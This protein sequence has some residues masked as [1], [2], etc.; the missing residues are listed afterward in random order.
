MRR[1]SS[2]SRCCS[3]SR[4]SSR[5]S[6]MIAASSTSCSR[7]P[8]AVGIASTWR[9]PYDWRAHGMCAAHVYASVRACVRG[10]V[11]A[12]VRACVRVCECVRTCCSSVA[13]ALASALSGQAWATPACCLVTWQVCSWRCRSSPSC[14]RRCPSVLSSG[15]SESTDFQY[16][17]HLARAAAAV[18]L[19][20]SLSL[21]RARRAVPAVAAECA[22]LAADRD[23]SR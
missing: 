23:W 9:R 17:V 12:W 7:G 14:T 21:H 1:T 18:T 2:L 11:R 8:R 13:S 6:A 3:S 10:C 16:S 15:G 4:V 19:S 5:R 20:C 22:A